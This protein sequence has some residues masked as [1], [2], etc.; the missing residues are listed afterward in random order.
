MRPV[1]ER[2]LDAIIV[3]SKR[4]YGRAEVDRN[5]EPIEL[6]GEHFMHGV[7]H[8][9][10]RCPIFR[11]EK[12]RQFDRSGHISFGVAGLEEGLREAAGNAFVQDANVTQRAQCR[13]L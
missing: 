5:A 11:P 9:A 4:R 8:N 10:D 13:S 3:L 12:A 7:T 1:A 6:S 2:N